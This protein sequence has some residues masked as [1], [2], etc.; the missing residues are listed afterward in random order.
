M[1]DEGA[2]LKELKAI[3]NSFNYKDL[4]YYLK[5]DDLVSRS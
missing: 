4:C 5:Y 1:N 3:K 2:E